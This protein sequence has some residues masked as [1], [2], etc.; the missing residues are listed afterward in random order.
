MAVW[1]YA[2]VGLLYLCDVELFHESM[3]ML[4]SSEISPLVYQCI[5]DLADQT[6]LL[7]LDSIKKTKTS[8][9]TEIS[10]F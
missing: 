7:S 4:G 1:R 9:L 5:S 8:R 10:T 2:G 3:G 6:K